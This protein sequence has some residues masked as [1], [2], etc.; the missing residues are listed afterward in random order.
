ME[1]PKIISKKIAFWLLIGFIIAGAYLRLANLG[2]DS[3]WED[4]FLHVY[5]AKGILEAG[6]PILPS[7]ELYTRSI[8]YTYIV[9]FSFKLFGIN[10]MAARLPSVLF[11]ILMIPIIYY[12]VARFFNRN[13]G[14]ISSFL[15]AFSP[16]CI[17]WSRTC[18]MY[19]LLQPLYFFCAFSF[20]KA[21]EEANEVN[22]STSPIEKARG[23]LFLCG[24]FFLSILVHDL[25][26]LFIPTIATYCITMFFVFL[27]K[28]NI[29]FIFHSKYFT[30]VSAIALLTIAGVIFNM[31]FLKKDFLEFL[32]NAPPWSFE[33][34]H[35]IHYYHWFLQNNYP[36]FTY[37]Y[38]YIAL[39]II[40]SWKRKGLYIANCFALPFLALSSLFVWKG[41]RYLYFI[42]PFFLIIVAFFMEYML[43]FSWSF[44]RKT[45][46]SLFP[47]RAVRI[48]NKI[49]FF[50]GVLS[51][52]LL[53]YPFLSPWIKK[54][55]GKQIH[56]SS[57]ENRAYGDFI[58]QIGSMDAIVCTRPF[59]IEFYSSRMPD[60]FIKNYDFVADGKEG[61]LLFNEKKEEKDESSGIRLIND[62]AQL[63]A[64]ENTENRIWIITY[65]YS[66]ESLS[67]DKDIRNYIKEAYA[68]HPISGKILKVYYKE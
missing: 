57:Q 41:E 19:S 30:C 10:E 13:L 26:I 17:S 14:L 61:H 67:I 9:A 62:L 31:Y 24:I 58:A 65:A 45:A 66:L 32:K 47:H 28:N 12:V 5:A 38:P 39:I 29:R 60:F 59:H 34:A 15:I 37:F 68:E 35:N 4:E 21:F 2:K 44:A 1:G 55:F 54:S 20:Y 42:F 36:V 3:L 64:L 48:K 7:G 25:S 56:L 63:K 50:V 23:Y 18:R 46:D 8:I 6:K 22:K 16:F 51:T 52:T 43:F 11:G 40:L 33:D 53:V 49:G 27:L